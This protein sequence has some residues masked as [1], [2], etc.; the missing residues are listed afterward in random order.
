MRTPLKT[1]LRHLSASCIAAI[2]VSGP[3][4]A[5]AQSI[6]ML[7][8]NYPPLNYMEDG[9]II[10]IGPD[11]VK[12]IMERAKLDY[13]IE[14]MPWA[15]AYWRAQTQSNTCIFNTAHSPE[16]S[17]KFKWVEPLIMAHAFLIAK[18]GS[19]IH[20]KTLQ[21]AWKYSVGTQ[22]DDMT[23]DLLRKD[24]FP[25]IDIAAN[26][27][28]Q[29]KKLLAGRIDLISSTDAYYY[30]AKAKGTPIEIAYVLA[31]EASSIACSLDTDDNTIRAMQAQLDAL[32]KDGIQESILK[33]Y[34]MGGP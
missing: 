30:G 28:L 9:K 23:E 13:T 1:R 15:R 19:N 26:F 17:P 34:G 14:M 16:R 3:V 29:L 6:Q 20:P 12:L 32:I 10:G 25:K 27:D 24:G 21:E 2:A 4:V 22:R 31:A 33:K 11:Q 18:A 8:E 5:K 7:T